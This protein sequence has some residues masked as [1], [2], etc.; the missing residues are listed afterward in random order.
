MLDDP[1][2]FEFSVSHMWPSSVNPRFRTDRVQRGTSVLHFVR[3]GPSR[4]GR[5]SGVRVESRRP[6]H[7]RFDLPSRRR[8]FMP[9]RF[10]RCKRKPR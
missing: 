9:E 5:R 7:D 4:P 1:H 8:E 3:N 6:A 10:R 2:R